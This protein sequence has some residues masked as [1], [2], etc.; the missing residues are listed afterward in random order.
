MYSVL[1]LVHIGCAI[2]TIAGFVLRAYWMMIS[3][4]LLAHRVTRIAPHVIDSVFLLSGVAMLAIASLNPL[5]QDWL[6]AKFLGLIAYIMLGMVALRRGPSRN[7]RVIASIG[8]I[9][10]F[11]Y[12]VGAAISRSP[13]SWL[14]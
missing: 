4:T 9:A 13:L 1:K 10:V 3:S 6:V 8:A 7:I 11:G 12:I 5:S 14:A 2:L